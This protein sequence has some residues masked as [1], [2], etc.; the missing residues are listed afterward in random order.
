MVSVGETVRNQNSGRRRTREEEIELAPPDHTGQG[1]AL[2]LIERAVEATTWAE[3]GRL[4][5]RAFF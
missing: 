2:E 5:L 3:I 1:R 4:P